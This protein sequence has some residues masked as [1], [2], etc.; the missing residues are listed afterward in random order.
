M[1][2]AM[3]L[4]HVERKDLGDRLRQAINDVLNKDKVRTGDLGGSATTDQYAKALVA[5]VT[6]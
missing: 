4:D 2:A 3:M 1:A 5:R 6:G